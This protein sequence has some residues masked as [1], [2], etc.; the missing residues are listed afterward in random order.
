MIGP[1]LY[2]FEA[3]WQYYRQCRRNKR[4]TLNA[5]AFEFNVEANLLALQQALHT[6]T[7]RPGR[8]ICFL[9]DGPKPREVFAADFR[10]RVLH[11]LLVSHQER[12][13]EPMFIHD[14]YACRKGKGTLAASDR[15]MTFLR[16]VT[17]NGQRL[18]R[19]R[20]LGNLRTRL[21][22]FEHA[23][24][25][26]M[27]GGTARRINLRRPGRRRAC[28]APPGHPGFLCRASA[29]RCDPPRLG[30]YVGAISLAGSPVHAAGLGRGGALATAPHCPSNGFAGAVLAP[31]T[32][33][34]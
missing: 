14:S 18:P 9:T 34:G 7:Y 19:R 8:S 15:L 10:D 21:E 32:R 5:L 30:R 3:L 33:C 25:R 24:V 11:H 1:D 28:R 17:A 20:I 13:F 4:N 12:I 2:T 27:W 29:A 6:H 26:P 16:K 23:A 22:A 31:G